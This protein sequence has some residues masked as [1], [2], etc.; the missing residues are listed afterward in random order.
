MEEQDQISLTGKRGFK[1]DPEGKGYKTWADRLA[2][3]DRIRKRI[4][5]DMFGLPLEKKRTGDAQADP[6]NN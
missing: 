4:Y 6:K 2:E 3:M 1:L 5:S